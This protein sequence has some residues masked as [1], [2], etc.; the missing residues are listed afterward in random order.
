VTNLAP[1]TLETD[2]VF[3]DGAALQVATATGSSDDGFALHLS[4]VV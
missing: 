2:M 4:V 3:A 1:L